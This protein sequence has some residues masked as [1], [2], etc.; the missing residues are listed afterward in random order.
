MTAQE[1]DVPFLMIVTAALFLFIGIMLGEALMAVCGL[2]LIAIAFT[3]SNAGGAE[4]TRL[5]NN[6]TGSSSATML[7]SDLR[8]L[9]CRACGEDFYDDI[10]EI[11]F[12]FDKS[13]VTGPKHLWEKQQ[14]SRLSYCQECRDRCIVCDEKKPEVNRATH[15]DLRLFERIDYDGLE[16]NLTESFEWKFSLG[17]SEFL[18]ESW[19]TDRA[20]FFIDRKFTKFPDIINGYA[21]SVC[22]E[23]STKC[24]VCGLS[25]KE[26]VVQFPSTRFLYSAYSL[27]MSERIRFHTKGKIDSRKNKD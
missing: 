22:D 16:K 7:N 2:S 13:P 6:T 20:Q 15:D 12:R 19:L 23:C 21:E 17:R 11:A 26:G 18:K 24:R 14:D 4:G 27:E 9:S 10:N 8:S 3:P 1:D 25:N 5:Q